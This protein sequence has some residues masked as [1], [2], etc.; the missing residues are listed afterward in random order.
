MRPPSY[1]QS[2][3]RTNA[4]RERMKKKLRTEKEAAR[5]KQNAQIELAKQLIPTTAQRQQMNETERDNQLI[6]MLKNRHKFPHETQ[7]KIDQFEKD[8]LTNLS[9]VRERRKRTV[10]L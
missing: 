9:E 3:S 7:L 4:V 10:V 8:F 2:S 5:Q 1:R 6:E